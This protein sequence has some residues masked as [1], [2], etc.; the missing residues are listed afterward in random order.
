LKN[1]GPKPRRRWKKGKKIKEV[2]THYRHFGYKRGSTL[3]FPLH[4][5]TAY[6]K[7]IHFEIRACPP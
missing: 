3:K 1:C 7:E 2:L 5:T 6:E 4:F